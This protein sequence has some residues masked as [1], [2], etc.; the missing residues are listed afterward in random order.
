MVKIGCCGFVK[1]MARYFRTFA[2]VEI[3]QTFYRLPRLETV[4]GW[5]EKAPRDFEF[6]LKAWQGITHPA[7]SPT[8]R[9]AKLDIP[10]HKKA[11]YG[12][13]QPTEE[14]WEAW[15][16]TAAVAEALQATVIVFQCPPGFKQTGE[17]L[18]HLHRFFR[19][20]GAVPF[21][22]ALELRSDW[23]SEVITDLCSRYNLIHCVDPFAQKPLAGSVAYFR[24]HGSPPG[25]RMYRYSYTEE[26]FRY[27]AQVIQDQ[28]A[29]GRP[30]YC[31]FNNMEMWNDALR[32]LQFLQQLEA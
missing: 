8:Y 6:T 5:R 27:L 17:H 7:T 28:R 30:T 24:L 14:V 13:F 31:L 1:S 20:V 32:F 10:E 3:Q 25:K 2:L 19:R 29:A 15:E 26:D 21:K 11:G 9:K 4:Q 22:L 16:N 18:E 23:D 12:H